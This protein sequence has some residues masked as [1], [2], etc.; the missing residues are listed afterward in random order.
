MQKFLN[1]NIAKCLISGW[2]KASRAGPQHGVHKSR[3]LSR[4]L[5]AGSGQLCFCQRDQEE[6]KLFQL[7]TLL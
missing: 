5:R 2:V 3:G 1:F 4:Y 7:K 6:G